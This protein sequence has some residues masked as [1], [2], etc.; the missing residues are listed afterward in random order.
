V[1]RPGDQPA[2]ANGPSRTGQGCSMPSFHSDRKARR[3]SGSR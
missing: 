1:S 3:L 2:P